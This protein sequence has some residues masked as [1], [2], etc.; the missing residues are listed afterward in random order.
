MGWNGTGWGEQGSG[1]VDEPIGWDR[2][3]SQKG[4]GKEEGSRGQGR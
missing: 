1:K 4:E 3:R 2:W